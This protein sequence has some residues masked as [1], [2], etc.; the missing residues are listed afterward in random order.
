[1]AASLARRFETDGAACGLAA[2]IV[3]RQRRR[4]AFAAPSAAAG[5]SGRIGDLLARLGAYPS[6]PFPRP[7][8]RDG[9]AGP[10]GDPA[11]GG[12]G[13]RPAAQP[14]RGPR[15]RPERIR[16]RAGGPGRGRAGACADGP[17]GRARPPGRSAW[18]PAGGRAVRSS[19]W[20]DGARAASRVGLTE[21]AWITVLYVLIETV[22]RAG[23]PLGLPIFTVRG[24]P[25][26]PGRA[27]PRAAR[28]LALA[29]D[30]RWS[31]SASGVA[32]HA[33]GTGRARRAPRGRPGRGVRG[34]A[35]RLAAGRGRV[36]GH[37]R[38]RLA[39]RSGRG[40]PAVRSRR[41]RS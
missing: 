10:A 17:P 15:A 35:R 16:G 14:G 6:A 32:G 23:Y 4:I 39:R 38:R 41:D 9:P 25:G 26:G 3:L 24:V 34:P 22:G 2:A 33:G 37:A 8:R 1:M 5:Q 31:R 19:S 27:P 12:H 13:P 29:G 30:D 18:T 40:D 11:G 20:A 36:P 21:G 28:R 7:A